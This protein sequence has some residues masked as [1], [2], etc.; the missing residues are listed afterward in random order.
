MILY[1]AIRYVILEMCLDKF[2]NQLSRNLKPVQDAPEDFDGMMDLEDL[3]DGS[4]LTRIVI[5]RRGGT[6]T[7]SYDN[8]IIHDIRPLYEYGHG[9]WGI[10]FMYE[11][12]RVDDFSEKE[13]VTTTIIQNEIWLYR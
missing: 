1:K 6:A 11:T 7:Q 8:C 10:T 3:E 9:Y 12:S 4:F 2:F 5:H 13:M